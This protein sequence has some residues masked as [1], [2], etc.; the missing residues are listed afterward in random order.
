MTAT[1]FIVTAC[2]AFGL[3]I[4]M[5]LK[6]IDEQKFAEIILIATVFAAI[7]FGG[8]CVGRLIIKLNT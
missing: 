1:F 4:C 8:V 6:L 7:T 5:G 2:I 3:G